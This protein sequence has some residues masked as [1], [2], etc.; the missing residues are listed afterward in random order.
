ML[1]SKV[2]ISPASYTFAAL[3]GAWHSR[4]SGS[5]VNLVIICMQVVTIMHMVASL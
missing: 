3:K 4:G 5:T 1:H 2:D